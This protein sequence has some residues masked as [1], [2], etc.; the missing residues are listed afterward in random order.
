MRRIQGRARRGSRRIARRGAA[1]IGQRFGEGQGRSDRLGLEPR[2]AP[3]GSP[4]VRNRWRRPAPR[5]GPDRP[6][7]LLL[8]GRVVH[9]DDIAARDAD[10]VAA[11]SHPAGGIRAERQSGKASASSAHHSISTTGR[12]CSSPKGWYSGS[13]AGVTLVRRHGL[14]VRGVGIGGRLPAWTDHLLEDQD[15]ADLEP[16]GAVCPGRGSAVGART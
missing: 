6:Q 2:A 15:V 7:L 16:Q 11:A 12:P 9:Q 5:R 14:A 4:R 8:R 10:A 1:A 3:A 13:I